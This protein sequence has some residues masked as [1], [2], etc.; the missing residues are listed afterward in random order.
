MKYDGDIAYN[1]A[2]FN[3]NGV[4]VVSPESF[5]VT[6]NFGG[7]KVLGVIVISPPSIDST[8]VFVDSHSIISPSGIIENTETSSYMT[9]AMFDGYGSSEISKINADAFAV[10]SLNNE[11][12]YTTGYVA[13]SVN[14]NEAYAVS[15]AESI[16]LED[17][18]AGTINVT[19]ISNA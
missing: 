1:Q 15:N 4:Y 10:S 8:L 17:N 9:F 5:G 7:L 14:K 3:Y 19:I 16:I 11:E 18:S 13:I 12:L 6:S 2:H